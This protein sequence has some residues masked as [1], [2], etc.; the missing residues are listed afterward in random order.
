MAYENGA[1]YWI[2]PVGNENVALSVRGNSEVSQNRDVFLYK[3][4]DVNDQLW[5]VDVDFTAGYARIKS[6]LNNA[7]ALNI[8]LSTGNCDIHTW[9]DN[10]EDSKI[11]FVTKNADENKYYIQNYRNNQSNN[12]YLT[13]STTSSGGLVT[14]A[15]RNSNAIQEWKLIKKN[16]SSSG[17]KIDIPVL[18][19]Q[20]NHP[21]QW[22]QN[23]GCAVIAAIMAAAYHDQTIYGIQSFDAYWNT[24]KGYTWMTPRGWRF[25][26][27]TT[28]STIPGDAATVQYIKSYIDRGIPPLCY[29]PGSA[30]HWM[31]AYD[32]S[33]GSTFEDI[34]IIDPADGQRKTLAAGMQYSCGG[35]SRGITRIEAAPSAH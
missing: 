15:G 33:S 2:C 35:T 20:K 27:D 34:K 3:R 10:L 12:L 1:V 13:A 24:S 31:V 23:S 26:D 16:D 5:K 4:E 28:P 11:K 18:L 17:G 21:D 25:Q 14:W 30:G 19:S 22:I 29:C 7:Y 9:N 32:Y 8:Y 6:Q